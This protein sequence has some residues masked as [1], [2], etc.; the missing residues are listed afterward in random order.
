MR[1]VIVYVDGFNLYHALDALGENH[2]KWLDLWALAGKISGNSETVAEV[3]YFSAFATWR[4]ASYRRHQRYVRALQAHGVTFVEG[5][6]KDG[7]ARCRVCKETYPTHEEKETDV[8]IGAHLMA[9]ALRD[10]FD[11]ALVISA[12]TDLIPAI[13]LAQT[14]VPQKTVSSVAPPG[15]F[16]KNREWPPLFE[17]TVGKIR[18]SQLPDLIYD[19]QGEIRRPAEYAVPEG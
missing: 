5:R 6:F 3:K 12:D 16:A 11:R 4:E 15:R 14:E 18:Q 17:I 2:L 9:D 8:N 19:L 13:R 1:R 10:R 7:T